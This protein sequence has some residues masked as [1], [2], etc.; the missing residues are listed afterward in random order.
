MKIVDLHSDELTGGNQM[1]IQC[2]GDERIVKAVFR[3]DLS[4]SAAFSLAEKESFVAFEDIGYPDLDEDKLFSLSPVYVGLTWNGENC[5]ACGCKCVNDGGLTEKGRAFVR[6][7]NRRGIAVDTAHLGE[8]GFR[9]VL[10]LAD[11]V[12][13]SHTGFYGF[14]PHARNLKD[15]QLDELFRRKCLVGFTLCGY[16]STDKSS[17]SVCEAA[18]HLLYFYDRY[19]AETLAVGTDFYGCDFLP[20]GCNGYGWFSLFAEALRK[21]GMTDDDV[22]RIFSRNAE[23]FLSK[24][25]KNGA[26]LRK[27]RNRAAARKPAFRTERTAGIEISGKMPLQKEENMLK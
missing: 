25:G 1:K 20:D 7:M 26:M 3:G 17:L 4:F 8:K 13:D 18:R 24:A 19:G 14:F 15:W 23:R 12:I 9:E 6:E 22:D 10:S 27:K 11:A 16:F 21:E 5:L 2:D